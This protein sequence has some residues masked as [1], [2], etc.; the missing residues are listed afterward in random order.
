MRNNSGDLERKMERMSFDKC[1]RGD[2]YLLIFGVEEG[3]CSKQW[4]LVYSFVGVFGA[5]QTCCLWEPSG[6]TVL[7]EEREENSKRRKVRRRKAAGIP[8]TRVALPLP[9]LWLYSR[10]DL[11][12]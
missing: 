8:N 2:G 4:F 10:W 3:P 12:F 6:F 5:W 1:P 7:R 9:E 11:L